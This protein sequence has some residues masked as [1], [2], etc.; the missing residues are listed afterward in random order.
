M[1]NQAKD[2]WVICWRCREVVHARDVVTEIVQPRNYDPEIIDLVPAYV[3]A[4][5]CDASE[6]RDET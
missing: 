3:C 6:P 5:G 4:E 2:C 1:S